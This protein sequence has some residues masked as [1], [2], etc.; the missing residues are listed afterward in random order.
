MWTKPVKLS[1]VKDIPAGNGY[2]LIEGLGICYNTYPI[3]QADPESFVW[4]LDFAKDNKRCYR[5]GDMYK[6]ADPATFEVLNIYFAKDKQNI[7]TIDGIE[8]KV[9]HG[10]FEVLDPGYRTDEANRKRK[11]TSYSKDRNGLYMMEYYSK[12]PLAIKGIDTASFVQVNETYAK[13]AKNVLWRG[14]KLKK[15]DPASFLALGINY[16]KDAKAIYAQETTL[17]QADYESFQTFPGNVTIARDRSRYYQF[18]MEIA[19]EE[20]LEEVKEEKNGH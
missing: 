15:A 6:D 2:F 18:T 7:Y 1:S 8:K 12:K 4:H 20:F 13:D 5:M 3:K 9:D 14:K 11:L 16:G 19:E 17:A 10:T